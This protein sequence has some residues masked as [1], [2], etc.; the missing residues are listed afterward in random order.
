MYFYIFKKSNWRKTERSGQHHDMNEWEKKAGKGH[1]KLWDYIS[2]SFL[3]M[4]EQ[5]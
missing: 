1:S 4:K 2:T 3:E 5:T